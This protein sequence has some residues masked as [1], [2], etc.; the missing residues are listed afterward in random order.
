MKIPHKNVNYYMF[1]TMIFW[2]KSEIIKKKKKKENPKSI[3]PNQD[4]ILLNYAKNN[5]YKLY[6]KVPFVNFS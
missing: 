5:M 1:K 4:V 6:Y 3:I 2:A